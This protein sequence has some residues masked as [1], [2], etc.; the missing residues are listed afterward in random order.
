MLH[1]VVVAIITILKH[2]NLFTLLTYTRTIS[3]VLTKL[4]CLSKAYIKQIHTQ[5]LRNGMNV[6]NLFNILCSLLDYT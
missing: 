3:Y 5:N 4:H 1:K 2:L 6:N